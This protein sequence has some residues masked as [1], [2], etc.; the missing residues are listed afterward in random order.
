MDKKVGA[1]RANG[2]ERTEA[3]AASL[4]PPFNLH[5]DHLSSPSSSSF[6]HRRVSPMPPP[7]M[8]ARFDRFSQ[9]VAC[10]QSTRAIERPA[11]PS[12]GTLI[13]PQN[14]GPSPLP[15]LGSGIKTASQSFSLHLITNL[16]GT[17]STCTLF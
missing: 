1:A 15:T 16:Y 2:T 11:S 9:R 12:F 5:L 3:T 4:L 6:S 10:G 13:T 17:P 8:C 7:Q 14:D